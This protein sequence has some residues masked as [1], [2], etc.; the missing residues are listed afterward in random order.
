MH[1]IPAVL[2]FPERSLTPAAE[3]QATT[4][5]GH[6]NDAYQRHRGKPSDLYLLLGLD[7]LSLWNGPYTETVS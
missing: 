1:R 5:I 7:A 6:I 4:L 2:L 3:A